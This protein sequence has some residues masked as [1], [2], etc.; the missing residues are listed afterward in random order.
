MWFFFIPSHTHIY[1]H[2]G[3]LMGSSRWKDLLYALPKII[4]AWDGYPLQ[5]CNCSIVYQCNSC[6]MLP[7]VL[8]NSCFVQHCSYQIRLFPD[9]PLFSSFFFFLSVPLFS[10][11]SSLWTPCWILQLLWQSSRQ[12]LPSIWLLLHQRG[13][14]PSLVFHFLLKDNSHDNSFATKRPVR[15]SDI[16][17]RFWGSPESFH[18]IFVHVIYIIGYLKLLKDR[19]I[20]VHVDVPV[21][22]SRC[23]W[24]WFCFDALKTTPSHYA[25]WTLGFRATGCHDFNVYWEL[26]VIY[27]WIWHIIQLLL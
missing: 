27:Y 23:H 1:F 18:E 25:S 3:S 22:C 17:K 8:C 9:V 13:A 14:Q 20:F 11:R 15:I 24:N 10:S 4:C 7:L 26:H 19:G 21:C 12:T 2:S 5:V 6:T 16:K